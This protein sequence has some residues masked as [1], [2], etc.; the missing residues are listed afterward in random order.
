MKQGNFFGEEP[1]WWDESW[2]DMPEF[3]QDAKHPYA[4]I[5]IRFDTKKDLEDFAALVGQRLTQKTKSIWYP[6]KSHYGA[7]HNNQRWVDHETNLSDIYSE[8][9]SKR[10][11]TDDEST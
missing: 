10:I 5:N 4:L 1:N 11:E 7:E 6:F 9:R 2:Q 3:L 8:Q